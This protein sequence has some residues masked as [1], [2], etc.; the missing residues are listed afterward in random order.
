MTT[1][2]WSWSSIGED[3]GMRT[4]EH[5]QPPDDSDES[6]VDAVLRG[7]TQQYSVLMRRYEQS[8]FR[9]ALSRLG[10]IERAEDAVQEAFYCA[11]RSLKTFNPKYRFRTWLWT[12][13]LNTCRAQMKRQRLHE[14]T[15]YVPDDDKHS[16]IVER[17]P[18]NE[19]EPA[20]VFCARER[21][22]QLD[23]LLASLPVHD[24]DALRLRFF[25]GLKFSEIA[26]V[27]GSSLSGAKTRVRRGL[28]RMSALL[29]TTEMYSERQS[30]NG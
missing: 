6:V 14:K 12:I 22:A 27:M 29:K 26:E 11:Y 8:L 10:R 2:A 30:S 20:D 18:G 25:G 21:S 9:L 5:E 16:S 3:A 1:A 19:P 4:S 17:V 7:E 23:R 15:F 13:L 24:A 28:S